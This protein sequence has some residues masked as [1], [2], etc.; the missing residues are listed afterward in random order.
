MRLITK[1]NDGSNRRKSESKI[2]ATETLKRVLELLTK[3]SKNE[4]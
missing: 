4:K 1:V 3:K 2:K